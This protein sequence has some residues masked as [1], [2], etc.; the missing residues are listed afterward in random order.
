M[1]ESPTS[2][3]QQGKSAILAVIGQP[4]GIWK[5]FAG[6]W[7]ISA[8]V[9]IDSALSLLIYHTLKDSATALAQSSC[10]VPAEQALC[11]PGTVVIGWES[12]LKYIHHFM[13]HS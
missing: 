2:Q 4:W 13:P 5:C 9:Q 8:Y 7:K 6:I 3:A 11:F 12:A 1:A 10:T